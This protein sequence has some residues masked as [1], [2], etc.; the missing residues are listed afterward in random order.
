MYV[1]EIV[2]E[3]MVWLHDLVKKVK[4]GRVNYVR[5]PGSIPGRGCRLR[6]FSPKS[7]EQL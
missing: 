1:K 2:M 5:Y 6:L 3:G 7:V 4:W